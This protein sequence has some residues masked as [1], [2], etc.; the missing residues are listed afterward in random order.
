MP[1]R[2]ALRVVYSFYYNL[3][4]RHFSYFLHGYAF[5][6]LHANL[7]SLSPVVFSLTL[8]LHIFTL[9]NLPANCLGL[10]SCLQ[11]NLSARTTEKTH[12]PILLRG[13]LFTAAFLGN[14][15]SGRVCDVI[16]GN[17]E[18]TWCSPTPGAVWRHRGMS[19]SYTSTSDIL[20]L[21]QYDVIVRRG[22]LFT[23]LSLRN[24]LHP[25]LRNAT[26]GWHVTICIHVYVVTVKTGY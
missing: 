16:C 10:S 18:V 3:T 19:R 7:F 6:Q 17:V 12:L 15:R 1:L 22:N 13:R 4:S 14:G 20:P 26:M 9:R 2:H 11:D 8:H 25:L 24:G 21:L 5:T 23:L